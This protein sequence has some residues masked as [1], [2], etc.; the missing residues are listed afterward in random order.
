MSK[1]QVFF[2]VGDELGLKTRV[3]KGRAWLDDSSLNL[4]GA[5]NLAI[6]QLDI[7]HVKLFRLQGLGR[8]IQ[9]D[10]VTGRLF[11]SVVRLMV[12]QFAF[13]NFV[14]TGAL[15]KELATVANSVTT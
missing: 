12:G 1:Y 6:P 10:Y 5:M 11:L 8:V 14:K 7:K 15:F 9:V 13:I 4:E 2:H 3:L